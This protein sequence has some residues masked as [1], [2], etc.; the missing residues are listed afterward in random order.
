MSA[1]E[2]KITI[3]AVDHVSSV[4][5]SI[6]KSIEGMTKATSNLGN[7][8]NRASLAGSD[9]VARVR[10]L[11]LVAV[12]AGVAVF[13]L[14]KHYAD[15]SEELVLTSQKTG[16]NVEAL[17]KLQYAA[18]LVN[19]PIDNLNISLR[20]LN[21]SI[22]AGATNP[23]SQQAAAFNSMGIKVRDASGHIKDANTVLLE[24]SDKF[25]KAPDGPQKTATAIALFG[26]AGNDM[27]PVL[28][29]GSE[30]LRK[31]G[32]ELAKLGH[33]MSA[34]ELE[35]NEKFANDYKKLTVAVGGLANALASD[36]IPV[37]SPIIK[38]MTDWV[39]AN[40]LWLAD[41]I[42]QD[43]VIFG[44]SLKQVWQY[45][46]NIKDAIMPIINA[47]G[48]FKNVIAVLVG[49]YVARLVISFANLVGALLGV[50]KAF[51]LVSLSILASPITWIIGGIALLGLA[52]YELIKHWA[53][54]K[55]FM[56]NIWPDVQPYFEAF[57]NIVTIGM[58]S[59]VKSIFTHWSE[60]A[61]YLI[62]TWNYLSSNATY[63]FNAIYNS[64]VKAF[65]PIMPYVKAV[66]DWIAG[67]FTTIL[68]DILGLFGTNLDAVQTKINDALD[69][70]KSALSA[71]A[72]YI[73][74]PFKKV[75]SLFGKIGDKIVAIK[76]YITGSPASTENDKNGEK[77]E[78]SAFNRAANL[79]K[80]LVQNTL[81][82]TSQTNPVS[83]G[84]TKASNINQSF[85][86]QLYPQNNS[87]VDINMQID[88]EGRPTKVT[89]KSPEPISFTANVGKML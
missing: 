34:A 44:Q 74:A 84:D 50:A 64:V 4:V 35:Q 21:R 51:A 33:I 23:V 82:L 73:E 5:K 27:I 40:K 16:V 61:P 86:N 85:V 32:E 11:S 55:T 88:Y 69:S 89:A 24:L 57:A 20:F 41:N 75:F 58:Y 26:R 63:Y 1:L 72:D 52:I 8:W 29:Q 14:A 87:K 79:V 47:F 48:G 53:A 2:A 77:K 43:V 81:G 6:N 80:P 65:A 19:V 67:Y 18:K 37:L 46:K 59:V 60:I 9:F 10:N 42:K 36:L 25:K 15:L 7:A 54:V 30:A 66:W 28:N 38:Y 70:M 17:Q 78:P 49:L 71:F 56:M 62:K 76:N 68:N 45:L 83:A 22:V 31:Q 12:G 3:S 13:G 39:V